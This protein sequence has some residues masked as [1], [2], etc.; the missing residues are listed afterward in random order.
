[1]K[2]NSSILIFATTANRKDTTMK[3]LELYQEKIMGAINGMDRIRFRGTLRR[4]ANEAGI[5]RFLGDQGILLKYFT[6]W[7][8]S[9]TFDIRECCNNRAE[10]YGIETHYLNSSGINKEE[11]A[12]KIAEERGI[13]V[14]VLVQRELDKSV[15][16][17]GEYFCQAGSL[18]YLILKK[19]NIFTSWKLVV[20]VVPDFPYEVVQKK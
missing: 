13:A 18:C 10:D 14:G 2:K 11:L 20:L 3:L 7:A 1:M 4:L 9:I 17:L 19:Y 12:R 15:L 16:L 8:K 6:N 5:N